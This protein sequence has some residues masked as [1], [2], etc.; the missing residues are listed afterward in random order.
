MPE[1][2]EFVSTTYV[3]LATAALVLVALV[4]E[5]LHA[6]R[7]RRLARLAFGPDE[8]PRLW[9]RS[10]SW[11]RIAAIGLLAWGLLTL[12]RLA[13][14]VHN[15]NEMADKEMKHL[16]L[17]VDVS[18]SMFLKDAGV[19]L[20][21]SRR[22]RG[23]QVLDSLL[24][25]IPIRQYLISIIAVYSQAKPV[26]EDSRD[27]EVVRH[28]MEKLPMYHAFKPGKTQLISGLSQAAKM[29][30]S[31]NPKST[32]VILLTDGDTVPAQGM[33][34]MPASVAKVLVVGLGDP[35]SGKFIDGHQSRQDVATLRQVANRL[36]GIY[37]NGNQKHLTSETINYLIQSAS[38]DDVMEFTLREWAL[39]ASL[40]GAAALAV[41]P[42][43]L[44]L[45]GSPFR[46]GRRWKSVDEKL[47]VNSVPG[48]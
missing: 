19:D 29:A 23:S 25:R 2:F 8:R 14:K 4:A 20:D 22:E 41:L 37:H 32:I 43:A 36:R 12:I 24:S 1:L 15:Q 9:T 30:K 13:P 17:V 34:E 26:V 48:N 21:I 18:P 45:F 44:A 16:V 3:E 38:S 33:P 46:G 35:H 11:V 47:S 6:R 42:L 7:S 39:L 31:W 27:V 10:A 5:W 28:V 40:V